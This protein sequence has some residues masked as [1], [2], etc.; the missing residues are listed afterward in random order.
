MKNKQ[1]FERQL[2]EL[3]FAPQATIGGYNVFTKFGGTILG[4]EN[5]K[6]YISVGK[7]SLTIA[8]YSDKR[9]KAEDI[10]PWKLVKGSN[11][12]AVLRDFFDSIDP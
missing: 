4:R 6:T 1:D 3:G 5:F 9:H 12:A 11:A 2:S 7:K 10:F 8:Y